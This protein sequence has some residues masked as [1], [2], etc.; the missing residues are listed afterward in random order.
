MTPP[1]DEAGDHGWVMLAESE[2]AR[3]IEGERVHLPQRRE[4]I[5]VQGELRGHR[6]IAPPNLTKLFMQ[7]RQVGLDLPQHRVV[8]QQ[9]NA[10]VCPFLRHW[11]KPFCFSHALATTSG[12]SPPTSTLAFSERSVASSSAADIGAMTSRSF[13][14]LSA[15]SLRT[16][17]AGL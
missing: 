13:G 4:V 7:L 3:V 12:V 1:L 9:R 14:Y 17:S 15:T 8:L 6:D 10:K 11:M 5:P 16:V 2:Q